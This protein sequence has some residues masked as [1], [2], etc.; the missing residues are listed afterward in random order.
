MAWTALAS[1]TPETWNGLACHRL[2]LANGDTVRVAEHGAHVLSWTASGRE[3]LFLSAAS[4]FDGQAPI[5][6][7]I[8]LCWPQFN[9]RGGLP[10][11]GFARQRPWQAGQARVGGDAVEFDLQLQDD[12]ATR[13]LWPLRFEARLTVRLEPARLQVS[14]E[15][16]NPGH[17]ALAFTGALHTYLAF[18]E[19]AQ[20]EV[21]GL[22]GQPEWD[23][24]AD[25]HGRGEP[26][27]RF[28]SEF[29]RVY[30]APQGPIRVTGG[31]GRVE[32]TQSTSWANVV[33][34]N[35]GPSKGES[36]LDMA[37][38]GWRRMLCIEAAQVFEPVVLSPG[39]RWQGWQALALA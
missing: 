26:V 13:A 4:A 22:Q 3:R 37:P 24:V 36:L 16:F 5:R 29:D 12:E 11:H 9:Q 6:G 14:L 1:C 25:V 23:S 31:D 20:V 39:S 33:V 15:L 21:A 32:I 7:G 8:P 19:I 17:D 2:S 35:P 34:W 28:G 38:G 30:A 18:D 27:L 10:K